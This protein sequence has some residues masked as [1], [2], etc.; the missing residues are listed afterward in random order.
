MNVIL[1]SG[2][3]GKRLWP[4]SNNIRSKQFIKLFKQEDGTY[5]SMLQRVFRQIKNV[6]ETA[7]VTI[8]TSKEQ[9]SLIHNQLGMDVG[10]SV[11]PCRRDTFPA[12]VLATAYL[13]DVMHVDPIQPV[14]VCPVDTYVDNRYFETLKEL[15]RQ[16]LKNESNLV[17][18]GIEPTYP[19]EKYGYIIPQKEDNISFVSSFKEKPSKEI[20]EEYIKKG[21]L[22]NGG[23][24]AYKLQYVMDRAKERIKYTDYWNLLE[25]YESLEKKSFDYEIVE[26]EKSVQVMRISDTWKDLGTWNTLTEAMCENVIGKGILSDNCSNVNIVNELDVPIIGIGLNDMVISASPEGFLVTDKKQSF[27]LKT[28]VDS[29]DQR[30]MFSEKSWGSLRVLDVE[31]ESLTIKIIL[32]A[33]QSMSY[34]YHERRDEI[35]SVISGYGKTMIEGQEKIAKLGDVIMVKAGYRH[36]IMAETE[37]ELIEIQIGEDISVDDKK[38]YEN[39]LIRN[40]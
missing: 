28:L 27:Q 21:A 7:K 17:L 36:T 29:I 38:E 11:E 4:L 1:L 31:K 16:V 26:K 18:V 34:H 12:I 5:E 30:I 35:W 40:R 32:K 2:G 13:I 14:I 25:R 8:A 22:W 20:A 10:I 23:I 33:G 6:D 3:S 37:M 9:V 24:F 39:P 15:E 19:S